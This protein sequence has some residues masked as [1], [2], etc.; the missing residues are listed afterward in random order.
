MQAA[1]LV[2]GANRWKRKMR[3][4]QV[5]AAAAG[6]VAVDNGAHLS[7]RGKYCN[8]PRTLAGGV[9]GGGGGGVR[10]L[11]GRTGAIWS[12]A[13]AATASCGRGSW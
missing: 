5:A 6:T 10:R 7:G 9:D 2:L 8:C 12:H 13:S 11:M 4:L 1:R 3:R